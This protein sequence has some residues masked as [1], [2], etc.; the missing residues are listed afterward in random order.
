MIKILVVEDHADTRTAFVR[1][2]TRSG[3]KV[4]EAASVSEA[5]AK[6]DGQAIA[7]LDLQLPDGLGV[8]VLKHIRKENPSTRV[9]FLTAAFVSDPL[10]KELSKADAI[11]RKPIDFDELTRWINN[12]LTA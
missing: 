10:A 8:E 11:F 3:F 12:A 2:L 7:L 5:I 1:L 9:A 6:L 4:A